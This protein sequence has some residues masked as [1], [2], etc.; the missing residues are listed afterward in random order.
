MVMND[1]VAIPPVLP[2]IDGN[3]VILIAGGSGAIGSHAAAALS[4]MGARVA[5]TGRSRERVDDCAHSVT[6]GGE[7]I[8]LV[9]DIT[10]S[11]QVKAAVESTMDRWGHIDG[12]V[13]LAA[14]SDSG[15]SLEDVDDDEI[16]TV[17]QTNL[18]G[19]IYLAR[20][21]ADAM[22]KQAKGSIINVSSIGGHRVTPN[23]VTYG[24][25]KAGLEHLSRQLAVELGNFGIRVNTMSPGQTPSLLCHFDETPGQ[26]PVSSDPDGNPTPTRRI[27]LS[28][29]GRF[30]DYVGVILFLLSDLASYVTGVNI[31]V[32]GGTSVLR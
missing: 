31:W 17:L 29:L 23:R 5:I 6:Y 15:R 22:K 3:S 20:A 12:L 4:K 10:S 27:P 30:E 2:G 18:V 9:A 7:V 1:L 28:R 32:D 19:A 8:G 21:C 26:A 11:A 13:N 16:A 24:P 14:V 25:A